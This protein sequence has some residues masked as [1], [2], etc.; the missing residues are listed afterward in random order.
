MSDETTERP[1]VLSAFVMD[2]VSHIQHGL[3]RHP[4]ARQDEFNCLQHWIDLVHTLERGRIDLLFFADVLGLYGPARGDFTVN[5]REGLQ[6]PN[7]DPS[8]LVAALLTQTHDLG[9]AITS[10][11]LQTYPFEFAR[12]MAT[13]DH[14]SGGRVGWNI[15]TSAQESAARNFGLDHLLEHDERYRQA[16]EYAEVCYKLWEGSWDDGA[17]VD[18]RHPEDI[19]KA[20]YADASRIHRIDHEGRWYRVQGPA[21]QS[22]SPQRTPVL[23]QAG[24]SPVGRDF[25]ARHAEGQ[26]ILA[27]TPEKTQAL[28]EDTRRRVVAAG[29]D[30]HDLVF[31]LGQSFIV[32]STEAEARHKEREIDE[33]LSDD[34]FL[35]H[36]NL[37]FDPTTG[38]PL[39]PDTPLSELHTNTNVSH[40]R[41]LRE[42]AGDTDPTVRDL[43]RLSARLRGRIVGTPDQIAD[44]LEA[45]RARGVGGINIMNWTIP[46]SYEE[47]VD[48]IVPTLQER[49]LAQR[50]YR[51]GTLR[52]KLTG[53]DLLPDTH[54]AAR[55][56]GAFA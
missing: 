55:W 51:P 30:P 17:V 24:S 47:F 9:F 39:D 54:P 32:G 40:L 29:R 15:V 1:L 16:E 23:F 4:S 19:S 13:L 21:M 33:Y 6:F 36:S 31:I 3:W 50:E 26:F 12:R 44:Q 22:P 37:G 38:E 52:R 11:V 56:R 34:G 20:V 28:I 53:R 41:W 49:G 43:A 2:T 10:S 18:D 14:L 48:H 25:A 35:L 46:G 42:L 45:W 8:V 5:A 7:G 27:S